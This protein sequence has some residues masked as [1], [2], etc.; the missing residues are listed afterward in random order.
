MPNQWPKRSREELISLL[1]NHCPE[2]LP[3]TEEQIEGWLAHVEACGGYEGTA[4]GQEDP[5]P[6]R[7][8]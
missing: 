8:E 5:E 1:E 6:P 7:W 3:L 2:V 4:L